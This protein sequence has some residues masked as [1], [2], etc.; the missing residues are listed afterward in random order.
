M[1]RSGRVAHLPSAI[2]DA[3]FPWRLVLD[4]SLAIV[5]H[6]P[7][8]TGHALAPETLRLVRPEQPLGFATLCACAGGE[9]LLD[10]PAGLLSGTV[11][12]DAGEG[13][14]HV[15]A[16]RADDRPLERES[17][18]TILLRELATLRDAAAPDALRRLLR[19][20]AHAMSV[21]RVSYWSLG[22]G[23]ASILCEELYVRADESFARGT[24][25]FA[26]DF[27]HYFAALSGGEVIAASD[28]HED[29]R[30]REFSPSYL[31][32]TGIGAMLDVPVFVSGELAGV[33]CHEHV[34]GTREFGPFELQIAIAV[35]QS[36]AQVFEAEGRRRA[37]AAVRA[38][39]ARFRQLVEI[40]PVPILVTRIDDGKILYASEELTKLVR[41]SRE[42]LLARSSVDFY[43][44]PGERAALI[45]RL[46]R[47]GRLRE[48]EL[49]IQRPDGS[50]FWAMLSVDPIEFDGTP[51]LL[52]GI[53]DLSEHKRNEDRV[54][55][56]LRALADRDFLLTS[57]LERA[58]TFQES[59]MPAPL[60]RPDLAME[61]LFRPAD[62]VSG[63][64]Y[65]LELL[66]GNVL[67][68][69]VADATGHGVS[70][71]LTTMFL[72][73]EYDVASNAARS[74]AAVLRAL[75]A[76]MTR[77]SDRLVMR[78]TAVCMT[79][80][81][82][83]GEL[84]WA[85]AAHPS[86]CL[87]RGGR[88][89]ELE[90]GGTLV[91]LVADADFPEFSTRIEPGETVCL[92]TDGLTEALGPDG[93]PF[94]EE[95]LFQALARAQAAGQPLADAALEAVQAYAGEPRDDSILLAATWRRAQ[96]L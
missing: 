9:V 68:L 74:P 62:E 88:V 29:P 44:D 56:M 19:A 12:H 34:G 90:T 20:D 23:A 17:A 93:K 33:L 7:A 91:G 2:L 73:S 75:N 5:H 38:S 61:V 78:F 80:D 48:E 53:V 60:V 25:L 66:D 8:L 35:A 46:R 79:L 31:R 15:L 85:T 24:E 96:A 58:R 81:L 13:L 59:M 30:T 89:R 36:L 6:G 43:Y 47:D 41:A 16:R 39:E 77:F 42:E 95:R 4:V 18:A 67:R 92:V 70:A 76:R 64:A 10:S 45:E 49:R 3:T 26:R 86:P 69:F 71:A 83:T 22:E 27:P 87:L 57:D 82:G 52:C 72:R 11:V 40:S 51:A 63:D 37:E 32:P 14:V 84:V 28:A 54:R 50:I 21:A 65:D 94:G 55:D 1:L